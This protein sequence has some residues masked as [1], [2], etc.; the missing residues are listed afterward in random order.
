MLT[1]LLAIIVLAWVSW[2][3]FQLLL[4]HIG[5]NRADKLEAYL[6]DLLGTILVGGWLLIVELLW[7]GWTAR[8][9]GGA[10]F[11]GPMESLLWLLSLY[12]L[13]LVVWAF[14]IGNKLEE[15]AERVKDLERLEAIEELLAEKDFLYQYET[16]QRVREI[17]DRIKSSSAAMTETTHHRPWMWPWR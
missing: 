15:T 7:L 17:Q 14:R 4:E 13:N 5:K 10:P 6:G 16:D 9:S 1:T 8:K 12:V 2:Q 11:I 3:L